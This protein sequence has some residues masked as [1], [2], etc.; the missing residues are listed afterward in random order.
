MVDMDGYSTVTTEEDGTYLTVFP[1]K[2][3]G[4][5]VEIDKVKDE[6]NKLNIKDVDSQ[7]VERAVKEATGRSVLIVKEVGEYQGRPAFYKCNAG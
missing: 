6:I 7:A 5:R 4:K 3:K 1:P 2:G